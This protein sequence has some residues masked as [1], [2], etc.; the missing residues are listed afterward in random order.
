ME[1]F[2]IIVGTGV[3][4]LTQNWLIKR[5]ETIATG[6]NI[7]KALGPGYTGTAIG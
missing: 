1:K 4:V 3:T 2:T 6:F 5:L 7:S